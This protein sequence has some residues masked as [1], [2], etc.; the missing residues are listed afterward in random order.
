MARYGI[1]GQTW[2]Q[3]TSLTSMA[4]LE[5]KGLAWQQGPGIKG[6][7]DNMGWK[8]RARDNNKGQ[9]WYQGLYWTT[10]AMPGKKGHA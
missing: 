3:G 9:A 6:R 5:N 10:R 2:Q 4:R 7:L 8:T 1:K